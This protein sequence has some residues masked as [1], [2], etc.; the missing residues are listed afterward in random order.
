MVTKAISSGILPR[1]DLIDNQEYSLKVF[2][3]DDVMGVDFILVCE[4]LEET[5]ITLSPNGVKIS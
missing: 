4:V 1:E 2:V 5:T 3:V